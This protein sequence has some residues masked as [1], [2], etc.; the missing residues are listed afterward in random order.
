MDG[1]FAWY[2]EHAPYQLGRFEAEITEA[3]HV[4]RENPLAFRRL[5]ED[6]RRYVLRIFLY[7]IWYAVDERRREVDI[8]ALFHTRRDQE[9]YLH[10]LR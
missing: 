10:R 7:Q 4:L 6:A 3:E 2:S 8:I 5:A 1:A 9:V